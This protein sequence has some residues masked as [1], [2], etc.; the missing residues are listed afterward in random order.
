MPPANHARHAFSPSAVA[1]QGFS[2]VGATCLA[3]QPIMTSM[4]EPALRASVDA[5]GAVVTGSAAGVAGMAFSAGA[6]G[7]A[8]A[9]SPA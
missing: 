5:A 8:G 4:G 9:G 1:G 6:D 7:A 2:S 3:S